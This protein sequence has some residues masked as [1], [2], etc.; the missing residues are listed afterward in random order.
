MV[1]WFSTSKIQKGLW[2]MRDRHD[3]GARSG[4]RQ[5]KKGREALIGCDKVRKVVNVCGK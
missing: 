1:A 5:S 3:F 2:K 4:R